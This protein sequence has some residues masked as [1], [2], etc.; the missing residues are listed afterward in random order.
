MNEWKRIKA[1]RRLAWVA[2]AFCIF[3]GAF[4]IWATAYVSGPT[5]EALVALFPA[6]L[7]GALAAA[8]HFFRPPRLPTSDRWRPE[9]ELLTPTP[10]RV[11]ARWSTPLVS[12]PMLLWLFPAFFLL[13]V[14]TGVREMDWAFLSFITMPASIT[15]GQ[16]LA[17][18]WGRERRLVSQG[19]VV[20]GV[21]RRIVTGRGFFRMKL[22]YEFDG[23]EFYDWTPNLSRHSWF[24]P[25]MVEE[26]KSVTLLVDPAR[27]ERFVVYPFSHTEVAGGK[28][29]WVP[30]VL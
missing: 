19:E 7:M 28:T 6:L 9:K 23:E 29:A 20:Q 22:Q 5:P 14:V 13:V 2:I 25:L 17:R 18:V 10:R 4:F 8:L 1:V 3:P 15:T 11:E 12:L 27:P 21:I 24:G 16:G 30:R 26:R